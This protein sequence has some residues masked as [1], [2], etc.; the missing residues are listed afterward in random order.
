MSVHASSISAITKKPGSSHVLALDGIRGLAIL[1]VLGH[2]LVYINSGPTAPVYVWARALRDSLWCGVDV[3]FALSGFLITGILVKTVSA[4]GFFRNFYARR[5]L[6]IFPLYYAVLLIL[7]ACTPL[8]H[9][10]WAGQQWRLLTY[11][12]HILLDTHSTGWNFYFGGYINL[13]NFWS[14]HVEEQFYFIW[15]LLVFLIPSPRRLIPLAIV[16]SLASLGLRLWFS[17]HGVSHEVI[18]ASLLTRADN[19]LLGAALALLIETRFRDRILR[20]SRPAFLLSSLALFAIFFT[21]HGLHFIGG[22]SFSIQFTLLALASTA[23]IGLCLEPHSRVTQLFSVRPLRFFGKYSYGLYIFH[24]VLPI[25]LLPPL[26]RALA[27]LAVH[28]HAMLQ[29]LLTSIAEL[30]AAIVV[31]VLS[32]RYFE[33]PFLRLKKY[34]EYLTPPTIPE[35]SDTTEPTLLP[36]SQ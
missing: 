17:T 34:F 7:F 18:Y 35:L 36:V 26:L 27:P 15:P 4:P 21:G 12:N 25:F 6:R 3:F 19:L 24:T 16:L 29:H 14:L 31:S 28:G 1:M 8:L 11:S 13:V 22:I 5:V 30:A 10:H 9:I 33:S 2:H 32:Y 20:A 23:L